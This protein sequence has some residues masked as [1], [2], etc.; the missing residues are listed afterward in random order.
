MGLFDRKPEPATSKRKIPKLDPAFFLDIQ[1][2]LR[3]NGSDESVQAIA[4]GVATG[5]YNTSMNYFIRLG[6][7][8]AGDDFERRFD[9]R[10]HESTAA[11]DEMIDHMIRVDAGTELF[12]TTLL[13]RVRQ[14]LSEPTPN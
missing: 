14:V 12:L 9:R 5:V 3:A 6:D 13:E 11:A 4:D 2:A 10:R 7:R 8:R 1:S